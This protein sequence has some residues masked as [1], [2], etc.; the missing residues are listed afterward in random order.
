MLH[1]HHAL[2]QDFSGL[3][4]RQDR[5]QFLEHELGRVEIRMC[6]EDAQDRVSH[7]TAQIDQ[8][9][10]VFGGV[11]LAEIIEPRQRHAGAGVCETGLEGGETGRV[12]GH[13]FPDRRALLLGFPGVGRVPLVR[14]LLETFLV[15]V[16]VEVVDHQE[17][18][19][20]EHLEI[21]AGA[22]ML[23]KHEGELGVAVFLVF[24]LSDEAG[25]DDHA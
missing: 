23:G 13:D 3:G 25:A 22:G 14:G 11:E 2:G 7:S 1:Q 20:K 17:A 9:R 21:V 18:F 10:H 12:L 19:V 15:Q 8:D 16:E 6:F 4:L 5:R 24:V